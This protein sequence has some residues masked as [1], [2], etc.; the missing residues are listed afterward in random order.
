MYRVVG[1]GGGL[2]AVSIPLKTSNSKCIFSFFVKT[3]HF[4]TTV[5][6]ESAGLTRCLTKNSDTFCKEKLILREFSAK[7]SKIKESY[8]LQEMESG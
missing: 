7:L 8:T 1:A 6:N 2:L 4:Y 5:F 3:N